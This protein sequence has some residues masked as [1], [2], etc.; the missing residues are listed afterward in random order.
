[1]LSV[2]TSKTFPLSSVKPLGSIREYRSFCLEV[3][4]EALAQGPLQK[5]TRSPFGNAVMEHFGEVGGL[6]YCRCP[7][8]G[9]L[10]LEQLPPAEIWSRLLKQVAQRRSSSQSFH[11][12][13]VGSRTDNVYV[14]KLDWVID[15]L[16]M[17]DH[18]RTRILEVVTPP[19][20]FTRL[21]TDSGV[22]ER[23]STVDEMSLISADI[24]LEAMEAAVLLESLDRV[25]E[26]RLLLEQ[27]R[28]W[29]VPGGLVFISAV[30]SSGFDVAVLGTRDLYLYPPDRANCFSLKGLRSLLEDQGF[31]LLEVSTP[32]VLDLE[33]VNA[34]AKDD[35][36]LALSDFERQLVKSD[37]QTSEAF[38]SFLQ[39]SGLS[40]FAR[41]VGKKK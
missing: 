5:R 4:R 16:K 7:I 24:A 22:F 11:S 19:S 28:R 14:P 32:G 35:P 2:Q 18:D 33:V 37:A 15:F 38:Q 6:T 13:L 8:T 26:P 10:F 3:T 20:S 1:M 9:S 17:Q 12:S 27:L 30:V 41:V 31:E 29:L 40:S 34:H 36:K 23:V 25:C 21:L 39:Q